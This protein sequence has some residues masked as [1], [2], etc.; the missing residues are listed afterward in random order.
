MIFLTP[1]IVLT[2][3]C[4]LLFI[5]NW[6]VILLG[7]MVV[8]VDLGMASFKI[9]NV[10]YKCVTMVHVVLLIIIVIFVS[11]FISNHFYYISI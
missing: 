8:G 5:H 6:I 11:L 7:C 1:K 3:I 4:V 2:P 10:M 9:S